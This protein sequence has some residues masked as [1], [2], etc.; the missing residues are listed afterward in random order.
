ME[1]NSGDVRRSREQPTTHHYFSKF[2][3]TAGC[4]GIVLDAYTAQWIFE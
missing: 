2:L 1:S 3:A 4:D